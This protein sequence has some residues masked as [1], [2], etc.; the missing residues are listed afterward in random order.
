MIQDIDRQR[1]YEAQEQ[2]ALARINKANALSFTINTEGWEIIANTLEDM[3]D[4]QL[5]ELSRQNPGNEKAVLA[6]HAVWYAVVGSINQLMSG[7]DLVIREVEIAK[8]ELKEL[9]SQEFQE[10]EE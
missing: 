1:A 10:N 7:I 6:A 2:D 9:R 3:K 5:E 4:N 8:Q